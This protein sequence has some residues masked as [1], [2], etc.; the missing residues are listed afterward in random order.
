MGQDL[1][2]G[3]QK[4]ELAREDHGFLTMGERTDSFKLS[5]E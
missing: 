5:A 1:G 2:L 4:Q 3:G